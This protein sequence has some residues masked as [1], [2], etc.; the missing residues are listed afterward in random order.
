MPHRPSRRHAPHVAKY[1]RRGWAGRFQPVAG[2]QIWAI[3]WK[4]RRSLP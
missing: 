2:L 1:L 3:T 4:V